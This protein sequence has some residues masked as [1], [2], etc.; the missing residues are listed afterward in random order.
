MKESKLRATSEHVSTEHTN[1]LRDV[2]ARMGNR[3]ELE[4]LIRARSRMLITDRRKADNIANEIIDE[5]PKRAEDLTALEKNKH[6]KAEQLVLD[7]RLNWEPLIRSI[8]QRFDELVKQFQ[9]KGVKLECIENDAFPLTV[10]YGGRDSEIRTLRV[11]GVGADQAAHFFY[12]AIRLDPEDQGYAALRISVIESGEMFLLTI[13]ADGA[14][15]S[16][17]TPETKETKS[18]KM[19]TAKDGNIPPDFRE[20]VDQGLVNVFERLMLLQATHAGTSDAP[21]SWRYK[22]SPP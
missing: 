11:P 2:A 6:D 19:A 20:F 1:L 16:R 22:Q 3:K 14:E 10:F 15:C 13:T 12:S 7:F 21:D 4:E 8:I 5:L 17:T 18:H 9:A